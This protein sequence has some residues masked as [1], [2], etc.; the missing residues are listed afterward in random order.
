MKFRVLVVDDEPAPCRRLSRLLQELPDVEVLGECA[1]GAAAVA[2][3]HERQ[4]NLVFLDVQMPE[5]NGFEVINAVGPDRMPLVVFVTAY[6][7]FA[8]QAFEAQA[9]DYLLKPFGDE[10][11]RKA[12]ERARVF[13]AGGEQKSFQAQLSTLLRVASDNWQIP[14]LLVKSGD[15]TLLLRPREI[16]WIEADDDYVHLHIGQE[17]HLLRATL[18]KL[19]QR[20]SSEGFVRIHRSR[21]VNLERIK[22][23]RP[24]FHGES[25]VVLKNGTRLNASQSCLRNLQERLTAML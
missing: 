8:L 21:L 2:A 6:D 11:V 9:L 12:L 20:L 5:M 18:G 22:E 15:R 17:S 7:E 19:E 23:F 10:R 14:C 13:L 25:V 4:P 1:D 3:I 16:D 24:L